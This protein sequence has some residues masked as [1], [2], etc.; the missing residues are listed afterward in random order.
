MILSF[1]YEY[2]VGFDNYSNIVTGHRRADSRLFM[3][4]GTDLQ[5]KYSKNNMISR[6]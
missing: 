5:I 2:V 6:T 4:K 3:L 1:G